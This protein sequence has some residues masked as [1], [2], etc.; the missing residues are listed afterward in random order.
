MSTTNDGGIHPMVMKAAKSWFASNTGFTA[1]DAPGE[2]ESISLLYIENAQAALEAC[3]AL[4]CLKALESFVNNSSA[5]VNM[6]VE[7]EHGEV[8]IAKARDL[9]SAY[10][11]YGSAP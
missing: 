6:P 2:W 5:Q 1:E 7:C 4:E 10:Q 8:A 9:S 3:G 11:A